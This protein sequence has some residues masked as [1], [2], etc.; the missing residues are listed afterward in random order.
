MLDHVEEC[1]MEGV[2]IIIRLGQAPLHMFKKSAQASP[3]LIATWIQDLTVNGVHNGQQGGR[4]PVC[5]HDEMNLNL[6][7][8]ALLNSCTPSL[9]DEIH[10][11]LPDYPDRSG[12]RVYYEVIQLVATLSIS[13]TRVLESQLRDL[14]LRVIDGE[15][16]KVYSQKAMA[17]VDEIRMTALLPEL[18]PDLASFVLMGLYDASD[19][20]LCAKAHKDGVKRT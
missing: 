8:T 16:V 2:F 1:G 9:R 5:P 17:I 18:V 19:D 11:K 15:N 4:L 14:S 12:P 10:R 13:H 6:S 7:G 20:N 3:A